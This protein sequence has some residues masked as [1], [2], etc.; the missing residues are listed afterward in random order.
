[1]T[2]RS[3]DTE[4]TWPDLPDRYGA[5]LRDAVAYILD[6]Y[7]EDA[8]GI[9]ASGTIV[10]GSPDP[11]SDL[12][13]YVVHGKP[14]RQ[15]L[16][17][18]FRGVPAEI[19]VNPP[20]VIRKYFEA[21]HRDGRPVTAHM[22]STGTVILARDPVVHELC[23]E[24]AAWMERSFTP[25]ED[26]LLAERYHAATLYEDARDVAK[27]D[28]ATAVLLLGQ[29]VLRMV[30]YWFRSHGHFIPRGKEQIDR[31]T[32]LDR[33][34][35]RAVRAFFLALPEK[36]WELAEYIARRTIGVEGFFEWESE[37]EDVAG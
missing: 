10:G 32:A 6:R 7:R 12:D 36:R 2:K 18:L 24:A 19:F 15:R 37:P 26:Q 22:L 4:C 5:A 34:L 14:V 29:A 9:V 13:L 21:E 16:Q 27:R 28:P 8:L 3:L 33:E 20:A 11:T 30:Q 23:S 35:G 31:L 25:S 1:M 17:K